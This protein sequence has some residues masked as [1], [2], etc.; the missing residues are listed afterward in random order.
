[1]RENPKGLLA[2]QWCCAF[3]CDQWFKVRRDSVTH[4][5]REVVRFDERYTDADPAAAAQG[6]QPVGDWV[7]VAHEPI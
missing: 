1:M 6:G 3:G 4:E 2:E 7:D 5:I